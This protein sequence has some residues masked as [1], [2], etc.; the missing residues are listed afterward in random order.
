MEITN[1]NV[2]NLIYSYFEIYEIKVYSML[3]VGNK[4][5]FKYSNKYS[6]N[7]SFL[8]CCKANWNE[9]LGLFRIHDEKTLIKSVEYLAEVGNIEMMKKVKSLIRKDKEYYDRVNNLFYQRDRDYEKIKPILS[10]KID[11][12]KSFQSAVTN[13]HPEAVELL[14]DWLKEESTDGFYS[15]CPMFRELLEDSILGNDVNCVKLCIG[16]LDK[17]GGGA[18]RAIFD[19]SYQ[20]Y[21][22]IGQC[23]NTAIYDYFSNDIG[24]TV[25]DIILLYHS[26]ARYGHHNL[27]K[28]VHSELGDKVGQ[29]QF[30]HAIKLALVNGRKLTAKVIYELITVKEIRDEVSVESLE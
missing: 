14:R 25:D 7:E 19:Y 16:M 29:Q 28:H 18:R 6:S 17:C 3:I 30:P 26:A 24:P 11:Y 13:R 10:S 21:G 9:G 15:N 23:G 22:L 1:A 8:E 27:I 20:Y 12:Y 5:L 2:I 4:S